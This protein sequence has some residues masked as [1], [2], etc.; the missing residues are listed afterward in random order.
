MNAKLKDILERVETWPKERQEDAARLLMAME[1]QDASLYR[2]TD[3]QRQPAEPVLGGE[4][5]VERRITARSGRVLGDGH[6][7][8]HEDA[9]AGREGV[10]DLCP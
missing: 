6:R 1:V 7:H 10:T 4:E 9:V 5:H 2:L 8:P 3:E